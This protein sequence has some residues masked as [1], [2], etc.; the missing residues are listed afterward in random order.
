M[1][2]QKGEVPTRWG[3]LHRIILLC[4]HRYGRS[5]LPHLR[6]DDFRR[7]TGHR[8]VADFYLTKLAA[9]HKA[10]VATFDTRIQAITAPEALELISR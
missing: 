2:H 1:H 3:S 8:Q 10:K 9:L 5:E 7:M 6:R 4:R